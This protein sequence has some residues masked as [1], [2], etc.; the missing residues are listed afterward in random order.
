M[1]HEIPA[2]PKLA[3]LVARYLEKKAEACA[4]GAAASP[5]EV[6]PYEAGPVQP[7]DPKLAWDESLEAIAL[8]G[9]VANMRSWKAPPAWP[10]LVAGHE[11]VV[12]LAMSAA[13]FPQLV[14]NFHMILQMTD[15]T[16][17]KPQAGRPIPVPELAVWA[18]DL[19]ARKQF[20]QMLLAL[21]TLRLAK[22]LDAAG[23]YARKHD[24]EVP[25]AWRS[26]WDNEKAALAWHA[27]RT[28]EALAAWQV[29]EPTVPVLFNRGMAELFL[30]EV[31]A[32]REHLAAAVAQ[33]PE[34]SAWHHLG[35]LYLTLA[36]K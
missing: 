1:S 15:L 20:P 4:V 28:D 34:T 26:A 6:T 5:D 31:A 22:Q 8:A 36:Q 19:A 21:G 3:D 14:R 29:L 24:A 30:G 27:G 9:P 10:S 17:L 32:A 7:I 35:R 2:Q 13:N 12:A 18:D 16:A 11:P 25:P 33:L 23:E